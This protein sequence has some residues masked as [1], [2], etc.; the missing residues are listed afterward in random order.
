MI[1]TSKIDLTVRRRLIMLSLG[2]AG[3]GLVVRATR[4]SI[5]V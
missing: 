3:R 5:P 1:L 4:L 2:A